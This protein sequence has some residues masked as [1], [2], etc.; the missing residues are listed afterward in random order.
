MIWEPL[1]CALLSDVWF[2]MWK[3]RDG[4]H[5]WVDYFCLGCWECSQDLLAAPESGEPPSS[6]PPC[7]PTSSHCLLDWGR[8][9]GGCY[10]PGEARFQWEINF[11]SDTWFLPPWQLGAEKAKPGVTMWRDGVCQGYRNRIESPPGSRHSRLWGLTVTKERSSLFEYFPPSNVRKVQSVKTF[12]PSC[13]TPILVPQGSQAHSL[14]PE[15][16]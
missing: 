3:E 8:D 10:S 6:K 11:V 9:A 1:S 13:S 15:H 4:L 5:V 14:N 2:T 7:L 16:T 12:S